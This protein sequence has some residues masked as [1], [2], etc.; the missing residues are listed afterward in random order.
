MRSWEVYISLFGE[1]TTK[2]Y[3]LRFTGG[4]SE[5]CGHDSFYRHT[6][7][8]VVI[9]RGTYSEDVEIGKYLN[10][11]ITV[12]TLMGS[13]HLLVWRGDDGILQLQM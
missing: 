4:D 11:S 2:I 6:K 9:S 13:L 10:V 12:C 3:N 7:D 1:G 5:R 8:S